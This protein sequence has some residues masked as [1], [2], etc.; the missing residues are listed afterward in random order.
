VADRKGRL[1][2]DSPNP[3]CLACPVPIGMLWALEVFGVFAESVVPLP[4]HP[5]RLG[6]PGRSGSGEVPAPPES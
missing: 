1:R 2:S 3:A 5:G 6:R 4:E